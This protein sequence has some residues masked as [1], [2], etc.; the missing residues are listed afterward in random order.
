VLTKGD[1]S[2]GNRLPFKSIHFWMS[3]DRASLIANLA[4]LPPE[5][6]MHLAGQGR[7]EELE[8]AAKR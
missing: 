8:K 1:E 2:R 3:D 4:K 7:E 5:Y 6:Q